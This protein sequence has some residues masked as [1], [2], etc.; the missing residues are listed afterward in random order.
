MLKYNGA[1]KDKY[2]KDSLVS[3]VETF[4]LLEIKN[5]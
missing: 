5:T 2:A 4:P 3:T 1:I